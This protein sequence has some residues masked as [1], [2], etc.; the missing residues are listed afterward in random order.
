MHISEFKKQFNQ[1]SPYTHLNSSGMGPIPE[2]NRTT[3]RH[4]LDR[5]YEEGAFCSGEMW[6]GTERAREITASF[7]GAQTHQLAF[8]QTTASALSQAA[9]GIPLEVGDEILTW[10]QEYP[11]NFYPWRAAA[12]RSGARV[13]QVESADFSTSTDQLLSYVTD[14]TKVVAISW[15]QFMTGSVTD[16]KKISSALKNRDIWLVADVIQGVGVYPFHFAES[17]FDI[18]CCGSHKW[19]CSS[20]GAAFM[21]VSDA[22]LGRLK[23]LEFGA[24]TYGDPDTIKSFN[25]EPKK[26]AQK[27]EPGSKSMIEVIAL[28]ETLKLFQAVGVENIKKEACRLAD[29]LRTGLTSLGY[30]IQSPHEGV[31]LNFRPQAEQKPDSKTILN[32]IAESLKAAKISYAV[33]GPGIRLSV[34]GFNTDQDIAKALDVI[35]G[36]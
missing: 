36:V 31:I 9:L 14:K 6:V 34:H 2:I 29:D 33:R 24:M 22:K 26:T 5:F 20:Y 23:P 35:S 18:V 32:K 30:F 12:E 4:W 19:L 15:V 25:I 13:I 7:M 28:G 17:G 27:F 3:A 1:G 8:F 11:S 16:L 21:I 10:A